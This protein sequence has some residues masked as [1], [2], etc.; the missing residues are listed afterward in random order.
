MTTA[1]GGAKVGYPIRRVHTPYALGGKWPLDELVVL[2]A[3]EVNRL[4]VTKIKA[5]VYFPLRRD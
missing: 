1:D 5:L 3:D 2:L 4:P